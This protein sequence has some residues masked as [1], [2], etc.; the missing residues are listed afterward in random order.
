MNVESIAPIQHYV[1]SH[2]NLLLIDADGRS[3]NHLLMNDKTVKTPFQERFDLVLA[4]LGLKDRAA[5]GAL[6]DGVSN[7]V[8]YNWYV[9]DQ[10]IASTSRRNFEAKT[11]ISVDWV[12]DGVGSM[13][14]PRASSDDFVT[15]APSQAVGLDPVKLANSI[16]MLKKAFGMRGLEFQA[17]EEAELISIAYD[18]LTS[19]PKVADFNGFVTGLVRG[20]HVGQREDGLTSEEALRKVKRRSA[21]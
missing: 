14:L 18:Y 15:A 8:L 17:E 2:V 19:S 16:E 11:G 20:R 21:S 4:H 12:N 6:L 10:R 9:R 13:A 5:L 7:A 1:D 3:V